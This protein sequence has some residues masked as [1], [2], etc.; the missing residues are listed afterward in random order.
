MDSHFYIRVYERKNSSAAGFTLIELMIAVAITA[1]LAAI[2]IPSYNNFILRSKMRS[3][4][5]DLVALTVNVENDYQR[6][7]SYPVLDADDDLA[8]RYT[9]WNASSDDFTYHAESTAATYELV[10]TGHNSFDGCILKITN[11]NLRTAEGC[12][13]GNGGWL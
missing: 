11:E 10:A 1:I 5:A 4:Q 8:T 13:Q 12:P 2:A 3:A 7:L 9:G 6:L